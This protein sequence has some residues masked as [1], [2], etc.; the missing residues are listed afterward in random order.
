MKTIAA[1]TLFASVAL[2]QT[3]SLAHFDAVKI[4]GMGLCGEV[5]RVGL[6]RRRLR[7]RRPWEESLS[8]GQRAEDAC[9]RRRIGF[10][11]VALESQPAYMRLRTASL[12]LNALRLIFRPH[13]S[14]PIHG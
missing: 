14:C 8:P 9:G 13:D 4:G 6:P 11:E 10:D 1:A 12:G 3:V 5:G 2:A 7:R